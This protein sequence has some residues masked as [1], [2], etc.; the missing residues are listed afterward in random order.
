MTNYYVYYRIGPYARTELTRVVGEMFAA[1]AEQ[2]GV[3]GRWMHRRDD[4]STC[5]E[6]YEEVHEAAR[7]EALLE[8]EAQR[9]GF[10]RFLAPGAARHTECFVAAQD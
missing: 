5:M 1:V 10:Q 8:R 2:T 7:F 9:R 6:V 3:Q 4:P